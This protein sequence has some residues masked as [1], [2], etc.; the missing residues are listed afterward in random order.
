MQGEY[1]QSLERCLPG[2]LLKKREGGQVFWR[3][4]CFNG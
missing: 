2:F 1:C 3:N 4:F